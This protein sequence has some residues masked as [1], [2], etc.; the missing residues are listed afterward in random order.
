MLFV[1]GICD[2][3]DLLLPEPPLLVKA[4]LLVIGA[5]GLP[6]WSSVLLERGVIAVEPEAPLP[7]RQR[8]GSSW[9]EVQAIL[10]NKNAEFDGSSYVRLLDVFKAIS[11]T[12]TNK[13]P[14][15][16]MKTNS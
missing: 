16:K 3:P 4:Q 15:Q 7:K 6:K 14:G 11:V 5:D 13:N 1:V 9:D 2:T 12:K 10:H 8:R